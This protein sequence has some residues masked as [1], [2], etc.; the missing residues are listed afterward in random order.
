MNA[1]DA[2]P[3]AIS[4]DE[5][6]DFIESA[7]RLKLWFVRQHLQSH[8]AE[9]FRNA[10]DHR[11]DIWRKTSLNPAHLDG[12]WQLEKCPVW[13]SL[14]AELEELHRATLGE[15]TAAAFEERGIALLRPYLHARVERDLEDIRNKVDLQSYQCGSLRHNLEVSP[16]YPQRIG[17]H[18]ANDCYPRSPFDDSHYFPACF[19]DLMDRCAEQ[20]GVLEIGT[21]TWLN[22]VPRWL[23]MFPS[24]WA[25]H[26]GPPLTDVR[27]HYGF[28]GQFITARKTFNHKLGAKF[29]QTGIMPYALRSSWCTTAAMREHLQHYEQEGSRRS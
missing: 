15:T 9:T 27:W 8:P 20:F 26:M 14:A 22:S 2:N 1:H 4:R 5:H 12:P 28:W 18:I 23:R 3:G 11:V 17:F 19:L 24:E 6:L 10:V 7:V 13:P 25:E 21:S 29:R 16:E